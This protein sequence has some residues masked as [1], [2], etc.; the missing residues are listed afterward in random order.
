MHYAFVF[1]R[2]WELIPVESFFQMFAIGCPFWCNKVLGTSYFID[3]GY[4]NLNRRCLVL[5]LLI[6]KMFSTLGKYLTKVEMLPAVNLKTMLINTV[7][8]TYGKLKGSTFKHQQW[9]F[10]EVF[11]QT[12]HCFIA[13]RNIVFF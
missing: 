4:P 3:F 6:Q 8:L 1:L 7:M 13:V 9:E 10:W 2:S 11:L 12:R 5:F